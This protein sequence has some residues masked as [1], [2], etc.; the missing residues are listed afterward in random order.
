[1]KNLENKVVM[2]ETL[3]EA[4]LT[5]NEAK[6]YW[7]LLTTGQLCTRALARECKL[8][9]SCVY[10][11]L[12]Q[13]IKKGL[14]SFI[15]KDKVKWFE[16]VEPESLLSWIR[17]KEKSLEAILPALKLEIKLKKTIKSEAIILEGMK[18][19]RHVMLN[20]LEKQSPILVYGIP[21]EVPDIV[22][23]FI[24]SFHKQR[25]DK[26][27]WM[28]HIYNQDALDRIRYLNTLPHTEAKCLPEEFSSPISTMICKDEIILISWEPLTMIQI[29]N[30]GLAKA[31]QKYFEILWEK[32]R[33]PSK[34]NKMKR[35]KA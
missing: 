7:K 8:Y 6:V 29:R 35:T 30:E 32:A 3:Q 28:K 10:D 2:E 12:D 15:C 4:G 20:F 17:E 16:A 1:M 18:A 24:E 26:K 27:V 31:Y 5:R 21:S 13:L 14:V 22:R 34:W 33:K 25:I 11:S 23:Y 9:R 19:F